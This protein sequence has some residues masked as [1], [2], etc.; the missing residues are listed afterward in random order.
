MMNAVPYPQATNKN[1]TIGP[2]VGLGQPVD[3]FLPPNQAWLSLEEEREGSE[4]GW[5]EG[6]H[7]NLD[8]LA[9]H[10]NGRLETRA[11]QEDRS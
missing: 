2:R 8:C 9:G 3:S 10:W 4:S 6:L 1:Q 11:G 5:L 7:H